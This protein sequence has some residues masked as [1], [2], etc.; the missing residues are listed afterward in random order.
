MPQPDLEV[1]RVVRGRDLDRTGAEFRIDMV[2]SDD[3]DAAVL[4]R[5][6]QLGTDQV[7]V[8]L[9][10]GVHRDGGIT[11]HR[12]QAGGRHHQMRLVVVERAVPE[13]D[14]FALDF[15]VLDLQIRD[16]GLQFGR[17]VDQSFRPVDQ[18]GVEQLLED[19]AHG[20]GQALVHSESVAAPVHTVT[21]TAHLPADGA[22]G[23]AFPVPH[24]LDEQLATEVLFGF[25]VSG[26]LFFHHALGGDTG[27][28]HTGQPQH[29]VALHPFAAR[30]RVHQRVIQRVAHVQAA[31]HIRG[32]QHDRVA[33]LVAGRV[34]GEVS[35]IDPALVELRLYRARIP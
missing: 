2:V 32:R 19:G 10:V 6:R 17:P 26:K 14:Q 25:S 30:Q 4:E 13:R 35:G 1:V 33:G 28:V 29:L 15:F 31:G 20:A 21:E 5:V 12:L 23:L 8:P 27:M 24:L 22:A 7:P 18:S 9:V 16:R 3:R 34:G 11:E